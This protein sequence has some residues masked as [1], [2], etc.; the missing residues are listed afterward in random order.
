MLRKKRGRRAVVVVGIGDIV[1][2]ELELIVVEV[3]DRCLGEGIL[4]V[5]S[6]CLCPSLSLKLEKTLAS[7]WCVVT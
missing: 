4:V 6:F 7:V 1:R 3:E 5:R 2:V